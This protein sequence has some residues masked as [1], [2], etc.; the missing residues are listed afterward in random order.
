MMAAH[1][2]M[3][4]HD[5]LL[6]GHSS[7]DDEHR[8]FAALIQSLREA[9]VE[10]LAEMLEELLQLART[11]F[12]HEDRLM[13]ATAFPPRKCHIGEHA[14]VLAS[15]SGV[16]AR[17]VRGEVEVARRLAEELERWFPAH[18]QHLDSALAHWICKQQ[19]GA[20]PVVL[21]RNLEAS[22]AAEPA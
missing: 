18:V 16:Q 8:Q 14:A 9:P 21:R 2:P 10:R 6:I 7:I 19:V 17:L 3:Y 13:E 5:G 20:K 1:N 15:I 12:L 11:H 22:R 4:W